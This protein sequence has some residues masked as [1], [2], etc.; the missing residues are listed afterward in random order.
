M[1][2]IKRQQGLAVVELAITMSF[3]LLLLLLTGEF[4]RVF[5]QYNELTKSVRPATRYLSEHAF[6]SAGVFSITD[7]D[8][9]ISKNLIVF[10][11]PQAGGQARLTNLSTDNVTVGSDG[12]YITV[13]V[14]WKY[15]TIFGGFLPSFQFSQQDIDTSN[16]V[17][18]ASL[19]MRA[20]N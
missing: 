2:S 17:L 8:I 10:G 12:T 19:T 5:Y 15:Q 13:S 20:L 9:T 1:K 16:M 3:L 14:A 4:G 11:S 18:R 7:E 6:N